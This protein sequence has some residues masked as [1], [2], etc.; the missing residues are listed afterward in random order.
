MDNKDKS[1]EQSIAEAMQNKKHQPENTV[2]ENTTTKSPD[3]ISN[4]S[5]NNVHKSNQ[6][7][8]D[9]DNS[10]SMPRRKSKKKKM[11]KK[12]KALIAIL[13]VIA[14]ALIMLLAAFG[15]IMHYINKINTEDNTDDVIVSSITD[16]DVSSKKDSS[17]KD[18][19]AVE[20]KIKK[21]ME[22]NQQELISDDD[23]YNILII[24]T[25][26]RTQ[27]DRGRSDSMILVSLNKKTE[28]IIMTSFMRDTYL[29]IPGFGNTRLNHSYAYGGASL[30]IKTLQQNFK[31][32]I[33][34]YVKINFNSFTDV[35]DAVN[36]V[37]ISVSDD[38][39]KVMNNYINEVCKLQNKSYS[40]YAMSKGGTYTLNGIQALAY[41]RI[42]YVGNADF[43]RTERQR[44]VMT[45]VLE[46][47]KSSSVTQLNNLL[48]TLLPEI[49]TNLTKGQIFNLILNTGTY[50]S[51]DMVQCRVPEDN[52]FS[53]LTINGMS[54]LGIDF[55]KSI[56]YLKKNIY[57]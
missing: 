38:E 1:L 10:T 56:A 28:K 5:N 32:R 35:I 53:Y 12:R 13:I 45:K 9:N 50:L 30:L 37:K 40:K 26:A 46:K 17:K 44:T 16:D 33:D 25:D 52:N 8:T 3:H 29:A 6:T 48:N 47:A 2:H 20:A 54:V 55:D 39:V 42:R 22:D 23:V 4:N 31:I 51:Y 11:S 21:N 7:H 43:Q 14:I 15:F 36:G 34:K 49:T 57:G 41:S 24:G 19:D 18:I 27:N